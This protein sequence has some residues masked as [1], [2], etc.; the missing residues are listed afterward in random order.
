[1]YLC[2]KDTNFFAHFDELLLLCVDQTIG[3]FTNTVWI[4][5]WATEKWKGSKIKPTP[6]VQWSNFDDFSA[7]YGK[8][9]ST[10]FTRSGTFIAKT[11]Q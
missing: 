3:P 4:D 8:D 11:A 7:L 2:P 10:V 1:M 6:Y 9:L 5:T